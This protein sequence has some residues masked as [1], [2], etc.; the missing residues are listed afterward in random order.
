MRLG[1]SAFS[2]LKRVLVVVAADGE[3]RALLRGRPTLQEVTSDE[4][5]R[6]G[7]AVAGDAELEV[8]RAGVGKVNAALATA[9]VAD[10]TRH[11]V[12]VSLGIGGALPGVMAGQTGAGG[13]C[14][15]GV[16]I[17]DIVVADRCVYG[18]EGARCPAAPLGDGFVDMA[19]LGFP[20]GAWGRGGPTVAP[21]ICG[22]LEA[23]L[24]EVAER[25]DRRVVVG[26]IVTVSTCSATNAG[27]EELSK[28]TEGI[29]E[30][31]EGAAVAHVASRVGIRFAE[32]RVISNTTGDRAE[33]QWDIP[34]AFG[35]LELVAGVLG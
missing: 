33:Q 27:A 16:V 28:R 34:R 31:M 13:M 11:G 8:V 10:V 25:E 17:G 30:A 2:P 23:L 9:L 14:K 19:D 12:V 5:K 32:V 7:L 4:Q 20:L 1:G 18:D 35:G 26:A 24:M 6:L 21:E 3:Y 15:T 29:A 22:T